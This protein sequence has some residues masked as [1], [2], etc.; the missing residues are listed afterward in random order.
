MET[1]LT[2]DPEAG[3]AYVFA[4]GKQSEYGVIERTEE[5]E[6]KDEDGE[7]V[8]T[9]YIDYGKDKKIFGVEILGP[10]KVT[11]AQVLQFFK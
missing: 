7:L 8:T 11:L 5:F 4:P 6:I 10:D 1:K 2:Y 9:L 3:A